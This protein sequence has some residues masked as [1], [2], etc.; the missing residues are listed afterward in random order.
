MDPIASFAVAR[1]P[2][3]VFGDG[4][5]DR[6][7]GLVAEHGQRV[8]VV[9]GARSLRAGDAWRR[10]EAGL[11]EAGVGFETV[12]VDGEPSP[13]FVDR[14][15]AG[16]RGAGVA[17][18]LGVG[19][20]SALDAAKALAGLI[21]Q[22]RSVLDYLEGVGPEVP[23]HGSSL[24]F[25]AVPTKAGTGSEATGNAVLSQPGA[26]GF[27]KSFRSQSLVARTVVVDPELLATCPPELVAAEGMDALTQLVESYVS[28]RA[29]PLCEALA[30]SGIE[31]FREGFF[32]AFRGGGATAAAGRSRMAYASLVSGVVLA[33]T[34]LG[35]VHGLAS[36]LG[37][38][39]PI[40]HGVV[41]GTLLAE[42]T[43][44]NLRALA[45][46]LPE[47]PALAKYARLGVLLGEGGGDPL[48]GL[49]GQLR[50]WTDRLP[51]PRLGRY[52]MKEDDIERVVAACRGGSM[53]TNPIDLTDD[54]LAQLLRR[55]L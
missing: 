18:V 37:A 36:P 19:G 15:A 7:P 46:R 40:P 4:V 32:A 39:F 23:Y 8:L 21:P 38:Y 41:C 45:E 42:A 16:M 29:N 54:E 9:T 47:S 50:R 51:L 31:A 2:R 48:A 3:I 34:G 44:V 20:G 35:S 11:G 6:V 22:E 24:P 53:K 5:L 1:L 10:L 52:G 13:G 27:K 43:E 49:V 12:A 17:A 28:R 33:Q 30:W 55:R 25:V 26:D 14:T